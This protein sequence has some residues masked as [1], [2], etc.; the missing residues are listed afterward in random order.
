MDGHAGLAGNNVLHLSTLFPLRICR[1][2]V[3]GANTGQTG[4]SGVLGSITAVVVAAI[5]DLTLFLGKAVIFPSG[6]IAPRR[7]DAIALGWVILSFALLLRMK[8][9]VI[10]LILWSAGFGLIRYLLGL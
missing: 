1:R 4:H 9:N 3:S 2:A 5:L 7:L 10:R 8:R 6:T